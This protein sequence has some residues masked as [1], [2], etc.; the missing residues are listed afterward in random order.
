M[1]TRK[2][3]WALLPV[4][5]VLLMTAC[6]GDDADDVTPTPTPN[7]VTP[8]TE[9]VVK[10]VPYTVTVNTGNI[11]RTTVDN[12]DITL[13]FEATDKLY[14]QSNDGKVYG[15]LTLIS[16]ANETSAM[17][18]GTINYTGSKP[19][20]TDQLTATLVGEE[21]LLVT[22]ADGKVEPVTYS[23]DVVCA[24]MED[25]V[26]KYS[27]IS[28][29]TTYGTAAFTLAQKTAFMKF[30]VTIQDGTGPNEEVPVKI[31]LGTDTYDFTR[32]T[33]GSQFDAE[34]SFVLPLA[35]RTVIAG[36]ASMCVA[37]VGDDDESI[38]IGTGTNVTLAGGNVYPVTRTKDFVRLWAGGP[39]WATKNIGATSVTDKGGYYCWGGLVDVTNVT[40]GWNSNCPFWKSG[41]AP[42]S[43]YDLSN[44][45][46]KFSK[47]VP[48]ASTEYWGGDDNPD[49]LTTLLPED[50]VA[51]QTLGSPW[52]MPT[53][54]EFDNSTGLGA[55]TTKLGT[56]VNG[57]LGVIYTGK[58][59]Y[60]KKAI[61][62]PTAGDRVSTGDGTG[63]GAP[64]TYG[65]YWSSSLKTDQPYCAQD[66]LSSQTNSSSSKNYQLRN[67]G[68]NV[69]AVHY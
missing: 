35:D 50:D 2:F 62:L 61:F 42:S 51:T 55:N 12:D 16:G 18:G 21:N 25:A 65:I 17:F 67:Y 31:T 59:D 32:T 54:D 5:A 49:N 13:R 29:E 14:V 15:C 11:T 69:R 68:R 34:I 39:V 7:P 1:K 20:T 63:Y 33:T 60:N 53:I 58:S 43:K 6:G 64:E 41:S 8:G 30:N 9:N 40:L 3:L 24:S 10:S 47:Y 37:N 48:T 22:T 26:K 56:T 36:D 52:R 57:A 28:G 45:D 23:N 66:I 4:A 46:L 27:W 38:R 44:I 19:A